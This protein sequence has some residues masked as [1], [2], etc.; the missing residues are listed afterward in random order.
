MKSSEG[1][2][3][4]WL[5]TYF[6]FICFSYLYIVW[7]WYQTVLFISYFSH[8]VLYSTYN[9]NGWHLSYLSSISLSSF[10]T[11]KSWTSFH[12]ILCTINLFKEKFHMEGNTILQKYYQG[13]VFSLFIPILYVIKVYVYSLYDVSKDIYSTIS[14]FKT[15][16]LNHNLFSYDI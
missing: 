8:S 3:K 2:V 14:E 7:F 12:I 13:T 11:W 15:A 9:K 4:T 6:R 10:F 16:F 1:A 5:K